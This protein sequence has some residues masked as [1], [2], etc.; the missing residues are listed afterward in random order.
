MSRADLGAR[1]LATFIGELEE[2]V[3]AMNTDLLALEESPGAGER[4]HS[5]FRI[6]HTLKGAARAAGVPLIEQTCHEL[7]D[8]LAQAR[9]GTRKLGS[10]DFEVLY[11]V[12]DALADA[13]ERLRTRRD[14]TDA[15][16]ARVG[17]ALHGADLSTVSAALSG[18]ESGTV[19]VAPRPGASQIR[20]QAGKLDDLLAAGTD[21]L[22]VGGRMALDASEMEALHG[23]ITQ[24]AARWRQDRRRLQVLLQRANAGGAEAR[25][26]S[27]GDDLERVADQSERLATRARLDARSL[28]RSLDEVM[29]R[30]RGIRMRPFAEACEA[31][32]RV[33]R[34][35][36]EAS[37]KEVTLRLDGRDVEADRVVLDGLREAL[38]QLVRNAVVHGIETPEQRLAAGKQRRG[39]VRVHAEL[40]GDRLFVTVADD[41]AGLDANAIRATLIRRGITP[42]EAARDLAEALFEG[43]LSTSAEA[44][45][46]S[47][48]G[49]GL[50]IVRAACARMGGRVDVTWDPGQGSSFQLDCPV[51]LASLRALLVSVASHRVAIPV[52]GVDRAA[53][54]DR[55]ELTALEGRAMIVT[56]EGP[57][58]IVPLGRL[59]A[60]GEGPPT[61]DVLTLVLLRAG[62]RRLA[63]AVD[64]LLEVR[65]LGIRPLPAGAGEVA[66][67]RGAALLETG[68]VVLVMDPVAL[69][70]AGLSQEAGTNVKLAEPQSA[71]PTSSRVLVVDDSITTRTLERSILE[72]AGYEVL[73]AVDGSDGWRVLQAQGCDLVVADIEMPRMDGFALCEAIR[74]SRR[75]AEL[76]IVLVTARERPEDRAR[77]L[78]A[79]ADA[80]IAKSSFDQK[81]LLETIL[82]LLGEGRA[83]S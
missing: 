15:P 56:P 62:P 72:A 36:S 78:E 6:A 3:G 55:R 57:V 59:L 35:L 10:P 22:V 1:L 51:T 77:G 33:V 30:A 21:L 8:L 64:E 9:D 41:G 63:V 53:R 81:N 71:A 14:L 27:L 17:A 18:S 39:T 20:V 68:E 12:A 48:R 23:A 31:L 5:L 46:V 73:T 60:I 58:P 40:R 50:D 44:T 83:A 37:A 80:Y 4:V 16:I 47:G 76:P 26:L 65:D 67:V 32:P 24:C 42:P 75:F 74:A 11:A 49:V 79:G 70:A 29:G 38:L 28:S 54:V 82:Q 19:T 52:V 34:D 7:E 69:V 25:L 66:F 61:S 2:Q 43:R 45:T 13:A